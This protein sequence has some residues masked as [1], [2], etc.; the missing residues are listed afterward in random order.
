M[1]LNRAN[2]ANSKFCENSSV[3]QSNYVNEYSFYQSV[4]KA[5]NQK[6]IFSSEKVNNEPNIGYK[7]VKLNVAKSKDLNKGKFKFYTQ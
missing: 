6:T 4:S 7:S 3:H 1:Y 5:S 2:N